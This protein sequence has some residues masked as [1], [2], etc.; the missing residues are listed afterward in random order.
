MPARVDAVQD[1]HATGGRKTSTVVRS[2]LSPVVQFPTRRVQPHQL[3]ILPGGATIHQHVLSY[4]KVSDVTRVVIIE[5]LR[6]R[7]GLAR[8][9]QS[10]RIELLPHQCAVLHVKQVAIAVGDVRSNPQNPRGF[11]PVKRSGKYTSRV[12]GR[13]LY[14]KKVFS[15][16]QKVRIAIGEILIVLVCWSCILGR[17]T[18]TDTRCSGPLM[19]GAKRMT[20]FSFQAP[21]RPSW[22]SHSACTGPPAA[23]TFLSLP[24]EKN[25]RYFPSGDQNGNMPSS[26]PATGSAFPVLSRCTKMMLL[27]SF[28]ATNA[29]CCPSGDTT[30]APSRTRAKSKPAGR[31]ICARTSFCAEVRRFA[32]NATPITAA[33]ANNH[34]KTVTAAR[35]F[36][37]LFRCETTTAGALT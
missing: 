15:I 32:Y 3:T 31:S 1:S 27:F 12:C 7:D 4:G 9:T 37:R 10:V 28:N 22:A 19:F 29:I 11:T 36:C 25:P 6:D 14:E 20:P 2:R 16:G 5:R 17:A 34:P 26:V 23:S 18:V 35:I 24:L 21:P 33:T 13:P 8:E 30:G